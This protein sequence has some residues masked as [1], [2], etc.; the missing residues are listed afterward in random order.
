[1]YWVLVEN[2]IENREPAFLAAAYRLCDN[3]V[4]KLLP[5]FLPAYREQIHH[6]ELTPV[7]IFAGHIP[8]VTHHVYEVANLEQVAQVVHME[9]FDCVLCFSHDRV[10][11]QQRVALGELSCLG[12]PNCI[13]GHNWFEWCAIY[14]D[15]NDEEVD[16][17]FKICKIEANELLKPSDL[18][19]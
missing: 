19:F 7:L 11:I 2:L 4:A 9:R 6:I 1:M 14:L 13:L 15:H 5:V 16:C 17:W 3:G 12:E 8:N 10:N 18:Q